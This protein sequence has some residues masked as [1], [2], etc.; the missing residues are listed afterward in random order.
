MVALNKSED[1]EAL[2]DSIESSRRPDYCE[3]LLDSA[4]VE[5]EFMGL[6]TAIPN[7]KGLSRLLSTQGFSY[8]GRFKVKGEKRRF[9]TR[10]PMAWSDDEVV[11]GDEIRDYLD[12]N[13]L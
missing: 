5:D 6:G 13:A 10:K 1:E 8:L 11:R 2:W 12:P 3:L 4:L 9:W 7:G